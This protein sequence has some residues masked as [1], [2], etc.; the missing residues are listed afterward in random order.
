[1]SLELASLELGRTRKLAASGAVSTA[2]LDQAKTT[3][4]AALAA[5]RASEAELSVAEAAVKA[6]DLDL[7][8]TVVRAPF[9]GTVVRKLADEGAMLAPAAVTAVNVGGILELVDLSAL[10]VEA[11]VSEDRLHQ[12]HEQQPALITLDAYPDEAFRGFAETVRPAVDRSKATAVVKVRFEHVPER[13]LPDMGAKVAFLSKPVE[14]AALAGPPQLRV[15]ANAVVVRD[16]RDVVFVLEGDHVVAAPV[17]VAAR[18]GSELTLRSGPPPGTKVAVTQGR[19]LH[20]GQ[21][22]R[23]EATS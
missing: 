13:A 18:G 22:V 9:A 5:V 7:T 4:D 10:E 23:V 3:D 17:E 8:Y 15:P 14:P 1:V 19:S 20:D 21:R 12:I 6:A 2:V 16:G 11:E